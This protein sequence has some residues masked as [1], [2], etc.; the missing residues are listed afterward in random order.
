MKKL[1]EQVI[2]RLYEDEDLMGYDLENFI[3]SYDYPPEIELED[4]FRN[5][6]DSN[7]FTVVK[8]VRDAEK[9]N[10]HSDYWGSDSEYQEEHIELLDSLES[11]IKDKDLFYVDG[12]EDIKEVYVVGVAIDRQY[13]SISHT[14]ILVVPAEQK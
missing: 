13:N 4:Q 9:F 2:N 5:S 6:S 10:Y 14:K 3:P 11:S 1:T 12:F 8:T 7:Y